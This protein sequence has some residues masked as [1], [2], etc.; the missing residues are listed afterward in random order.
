MK[1][2]FAFVLVSLAC[3]T[4]QAVDV[5]PSY[6]PS[7]RSPE[8]L[9][10]RTNVYGASRHAPN[11]IKVGELVPDFSVPQASGGKF[12]LATTRQSDDVVILFYRGHW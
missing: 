11:A 6:K 1:I 8:P 3:I 5:F 9:D 2:A 4:A 7:S 10:I 12:S